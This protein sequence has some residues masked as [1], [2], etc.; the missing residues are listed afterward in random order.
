MSS[1]YLEWGVLTLSREGRPHTDQ[2]RGDG[3]F[4]L[5]TSSQRGNLSSLRIIKKQLFCLANI[6]DHLLCSVRCCGGFPSQ[7][8]SWCQD[9]HLSLHNN[10]RSAFDEEET[11][12]EV[13][14]KEQHMCIMLYYRWGCFHYL[15]N[16]ILSL[17]TWPQLRPDCHLPPIN[18]PCWSL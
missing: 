14:T 4:S 11:C 12:L 16:F 9:L 15:D 5:M 1:W 17:Q 3:R 8:G 10:W 7:W 2:R 18:R 13:E 6:N